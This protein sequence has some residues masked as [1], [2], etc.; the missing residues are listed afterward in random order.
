MWKIGKKET[1]DFISTSI[2]LSYLFL[3]FF[4]V[5]ITNKKTGYNDGEQI[6][7]GWWLRYNEHTTNTHDDTYMFKWFKWQQNLHYFRSRCRL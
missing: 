7:R 5:K 2:V 1:T 4:F 3:F 6:L